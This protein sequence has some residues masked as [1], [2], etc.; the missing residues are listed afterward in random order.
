MSATENAG[1]REALDDIFNGLRALTAA[2]NR[3][4]ERSTVEKHEVFYTAASGTAVGQALA[5]VVK[6]ALDLQW[7]TVVHDQDALKV[8]KADAAFQ[9]FLQSQCLETGTP[10][11]SG[12][13]A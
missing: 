8:S 4:D 13:A 3:Y 11:K 12:G 1:K 5:S 10:E 2:F 6:S 9:R 7:R